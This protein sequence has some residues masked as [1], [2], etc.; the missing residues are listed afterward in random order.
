MSVTR[1]VQAGILPA[2]QPAPRLPAVVERAAL[3]L[4]QVKQAVTT[5]K[6]SHNRPLTHDPD[7]KSLSFT[8]RF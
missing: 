7:Q 8:E 5:L 3:Q 4:P 2:E 6:N 1:L